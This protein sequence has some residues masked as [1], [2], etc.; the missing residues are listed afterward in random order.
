MGGPNQDRSGWEQLEVAY[1]VSSSRAV[2]DDYMHAHGFTHIKSSN[3]V[4]LLYARG[5]LFAEFSYYVEDAPNYS[6]MS[7][8]GL[9][10]GTASSGPPGLEGIPLWKLDPAQDDGTQ[11]GPH[12][13][14]SDGLKEALVVLRDTV[15][16]PYVAPLWSNPEELGALVTHHLAA[17]SALQEQEAIAGLKA[18]AASA[19]EARRYGEVIELLTPV[20]PQTLSAGDRR[21]LSVARKHLAREDH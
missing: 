1:F 9:I 19:F 17:F 7:S 20:K 10:R 14:D 4:S 15:L 2:L 18:R 12:F 3:P 8:T 21:R 11:P 16:D 6:L 5:D 13:K